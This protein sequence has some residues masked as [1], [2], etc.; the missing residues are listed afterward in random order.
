MENRSQIVQKFV[1][2][3]EHAEQCFDFDISK[4]LE[5]YEERKHEPILFSEAAFLIISAA[6][7]YGRKVDYLEQILLEFNQRGAANLRAVVAEQLKKLQ[8]A[9]LEEAKQEIEKEKAKAKE[10]EKEK[11]KALKR[12]KRLS[13]V[14]TKIE[15][16]PKQFVVATPSQISLNIHEQRNELDE[17]ENFEQLRMKN[18]FPRI[19]ILQNNLQN[20]NT[21]FDN[22]RI[23]EKNCDNL[24]SLRD[25]RMFMDTIDEPLSK[26]GLKQDHG[27]ESGIR[28]QQV[29]F[30]AYLS[31]DYIKENYGV[32]L[33]DNSDHVNMLK[34]GEEVERLNLKTLTIEQLGKLKVGTYLNNIL[35]GYNQDSGIDMTE[36]DIS[37][38]SQSTNCADSNEITEESLNLSCTNRISNADSLVDSVLDSMH[39]SSVTTEVAPIASNRLSIADSLLDSVAGSMQDSGDDIDATELHFIEGFGIK[40]KEERKSVDDGLGLSEVHSPI[41]LND[42][43]SMDQILDDNFDAFHD[44]DT[45]VVDDMG[46]ELNDQMTSEVQPQHIIP[47]LELNIF[48]IPEHLLRKQKLFKLTEDF[49]LWMA[50]RKRKAN[51]KPEPPSC[52][53]LL[54]LSNSMIVRAHFDDNEED[55]LGF[56]IVSISQESTAKESSDNQHSENVQSHIITNTETD[57]NQTADSGVCSDLSQTIEMNKSVAGDQ[58]LTEMSMTTINANAN[59]T[60]LNNDSVLD[61]TGDNFI[62]NSTQIIDSSE[63]NTSTTKLNDNSTELCS[64]S[65]VAV[66]EFDSGF[67]ELDSV[68]E[69]TENGN[70]ESGESSNDNAL[71]LPPRNSSGNDPSEDIDEAF[72]EELNCG[73]F[74][75]CQRFKYPRINSFDLLTDDAA[76]AEQEEER[77]RN[78]HMRDMVQRVGKWHEMLRPILAHSQQRNAFDI[79]ALGTDIINLFPGD[80]DRQSDEISFTDVMKG[81]DQTYT[82]RYFLSL[83]L[84]TNTKNVRIRVKHPEQNGRVVCSKNDLTIKLLSRTRHADEVNKINEHFDE[85]SP[86]A[87]QMHSGTNKFSGSSKTAADKK[88]SKAQKRSRLSS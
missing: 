45:H 73:T 30:N 29:H 77:N 69:A 87:N 86:V 59:S 88:S 83:L 70:N 84:L 44:T 27:S 9:E 11:E 67:A 17:E 36:D 4:W 33:K 62:A 24:D 48:Q 58:S 39:E 64:Q 80:S 46:T 6:K 65:E 78:E 25:F 34:Y 8:E 74:K 20:N 37:D 5:K 55:F 2:V 56:S 68:F 13:K 61:A 1:N 32:D 21:F 16:K 10:R 82:A 12:A 81:R 52:S 40:S 28:M 42:L 15:F 7:I 76:L 38:N 85:I 23:V 57:I 72:E 53:K 66:T 50:A 60:Q 71:T 26:Q 19:N 41:K 49:D 63:A 79:H 43:D 18:V 35:H 22:L 3:A 47:V 54:K 14:T 31:P 51:S 75:K